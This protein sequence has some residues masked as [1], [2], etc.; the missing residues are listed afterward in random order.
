MNSI[1]Q[2][3][4]KDN[5]YIK[6]VYGDMREKLVYF[7]NECQV[8]HLYRKIRNHPQYQRSPKIDLHYFNVEM[9]RRGVQTAFL[10]RG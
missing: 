5:Q 8:G 10:S 1:P 3:V 6:T 4:T 7:G 9:L 2:N